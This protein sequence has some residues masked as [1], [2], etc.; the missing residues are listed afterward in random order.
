ME[1]EL[2]RKVGDKEQGE[3][4]KMAGQSPPFF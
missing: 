3:G 4:K 2:V 1:G